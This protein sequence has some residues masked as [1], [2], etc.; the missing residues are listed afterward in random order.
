MS[1]KFGYTIGT[2]Y[3]VN[4][5]GH[6]WDGMTATLEWTKGADAWVQR[7]TELRRVHLLCLSDKNVTPPNAAAQGDKMQ[8]QDNEQL[9]MRGSASW[10]RAWV[11]CVVNA[12][13]VLVTRGGGV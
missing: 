5:P 3:R 4:Q 1:K 2:L 12:V 11:L 7:G 8:W 13:R 9:V 10:F 6:E